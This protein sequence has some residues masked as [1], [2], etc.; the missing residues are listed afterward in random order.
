MIGSCHA[1]Y[2]CATHTQGRNQHAAARCY[3]ERRNLKQKIER[4]RG[5]SRSRAFTHQ[6]SPGSVSLNRNAQAAASATGAN[7]HQ[8]S[9]VIAQPPVTGRN[10]FAKAEQPGPKT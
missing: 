10:I 8:R 4:H 3:L 6:H 2:Q 7:N 5:V 1:L 9:A